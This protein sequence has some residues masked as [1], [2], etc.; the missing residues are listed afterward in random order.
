MAVK[1]HIRLMRTELK[2]VE[3]RK[4]F[5]FFG[6]LFRTTII[7]VNL[8]VIGFSK[9]FHLQGKKCYLCVCMGEFNLPFN[10]ELYK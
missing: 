10:Q 3:N 8:E 6:H 7:V 5:L 1:L 9:F 2:G 4:I